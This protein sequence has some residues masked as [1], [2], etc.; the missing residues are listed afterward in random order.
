MA[1]SLQ[2]ALR[3]VEVSETVLLL[4]KA[5]GA[6]LRCC[7]KAINQLADPELNELARIDWAGYQSVLAQEQ[8][9]EAERARIEDWF[10]YWAGFHGSG[11]SD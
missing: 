1:Y 6:T 5:K 7:S 10:E 2:L 9:T 8:E 3:F 4:D 11:D